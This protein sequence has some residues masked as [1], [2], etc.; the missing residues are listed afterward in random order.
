MFAEIISNLDV[1]LYEHSSLKIT[2]DKLEA[3]SNYIIRSE[4]IYISTEHI[5]NC[6]HELLERVCKAPLT[7]N[8]PKK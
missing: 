7:V 8:I 4:L 6:D 3:F 5:I 1:I 2:F